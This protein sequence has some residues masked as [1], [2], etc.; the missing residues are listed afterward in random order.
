MRTYDIDAVARRLGIR[1]QTIHVY[2]REGLLVPQDEGGRFVFSEDDVEEL[3]RILRLRR[4]LS[5]NLAGVG[6][7]LEMRKKMLALQKELDRLS[8]EIEK[9]VEARFKKYLT[10][11]GPPAEPVK[12]DIVKITVQEES[13]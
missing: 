9:E 10:E 6:V 12:K 4:D 1:I 11:S 7:I 2:L 13:D 3:A 8:E 5:V